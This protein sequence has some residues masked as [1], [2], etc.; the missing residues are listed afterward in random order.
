METLKSLKEK[1][2]FEIYAYC[3]MG[4]H[5]HLLM[6]VGDEEIGSIMRRFG[7]SFVYWYNSKYE[8]NGHLFQDRFKSEAVEDLGY[9][10]NVLRYIH[11]NPLK[12]G[13]VGDISNYLW[14]S[15]REYIGKSRIIEKDFIMGLFHTDKNI[16]MTHFK[17]FHMQES[18]ENYLDINLKKKA[19]DKQA[20]EII[21]N[22]CNVDHC[23]DLQKIINPDIRDTHIKKLKSE[24]L[25]SR[26]LARLTGISRKIILKA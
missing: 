20:I 21:K 19:T 22:I 24:G 16:A 7:A 12:A 14:C 15:Y 26:Q 23:I 4:N 6:K 1:C 5:V 2:D 10:L 17:K 18:D 11:Q 13:I 8:R 25:S 3:L 9:L